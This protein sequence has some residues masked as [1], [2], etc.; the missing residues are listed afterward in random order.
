[1]PSRFTEI[2]V[3]AAHAA[4]AAHDWLLQLP[5]LPKLSELPK[6]LDLPQLGQMPP[7]G[8][9]LPSWVQREVVAAALL[10]VACAALLAREVL[11]RTRTRRLLKA[12]GHAHA[13]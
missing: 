12:Y 5:K 13:D 11:V 9:H 6:L 8:Q 3:E 1:M 10:G 2:G 7:L 4:S